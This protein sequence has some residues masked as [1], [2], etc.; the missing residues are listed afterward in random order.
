MNELNDSA[1]SDLERLRRE[2]AN[3]ASRLAESDIY[4]QF[5]PSY[6]FMNQQRERM[7]LK[8]LDEHGFSALAGRRILEVGC[9][10]G[11]VLFKYLAYGATPCLL[12]GIDILGDRLR[13]TRA[14]LPN[15]HISQADGQSLPY[16]DDTFDLVVQYTALS[17]VLDPVVKA[18]IASEMMRVVHSCG[19]GLILYYDFWLNPSNPQTRGICP[20]EIKDLFP[21]CEFDFRRI[22]LAPPLSR[23]LVKIS[24][25]LCY[26]LE[27]LWLF[28]THYLVAISKKE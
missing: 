23:R 4:S 15:I 14:Y 1:S 28:N 21:G 7:V 13:L 12:H 16:P 6:L 17:S 18:N 11:S 2:Y 20:S 3:R 8:I 9:G 27:K 24:W 22:T 10:H 26:L 25:G 5:N 19:S